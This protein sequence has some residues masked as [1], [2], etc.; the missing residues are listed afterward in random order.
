MWID[1]FKYFAGVPEFLTSDGWI[2]EDA[3]NFLRRS[4]HGTNPLA[5]YSRH[6]AI[7][8]SYSCLAQKR[9]LLGGACLVEFF[10]GGRGLELS[11][12]RLLVEIDISV[13]NEHLAVVCISW[14]L[15]PLGC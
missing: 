11:L 8:N 13:S 15:D 9:W 1:T 7:G 4:S 2:K 6:F 10:F 3:H 14:A 5:L 12:K